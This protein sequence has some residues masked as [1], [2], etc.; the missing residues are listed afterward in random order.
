MYGRENRQDAATVLPGLR[1]LFECMLQDCYSIVYVSTYT[2]FFFLVWG[3]AA[4]PQRRGVE[5]IAEIVTQGSGR[6]E[7]ERAQMHS[8]FW[9]LRRI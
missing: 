1:L 7:T 5:E 8:N 2:I 9:P 6:L 4:S 3:S